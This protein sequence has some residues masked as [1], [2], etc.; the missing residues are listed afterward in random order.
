M[1]PRC[2]EEHLQSRGHTHDAAQQDVSREGDPWAAGAHLSLQQQEQE[3]WRGAEGGAQGT[4]AAKVHL[5]LLLP[6]AVGGGVEQAA[7]RKAW[8]GWRK[9]EGSSQLPGGSQG[10]RRRKQ[11]GWK[12]GEQ[13]GGREEGAAGMGG[14]RTARRRAAQAGCARDRQAA[15]AAPRRTRPPRAPQALTTAPQRSP[16]RRT[17]P[18]G[19]GPEGPP[20]AR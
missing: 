20:P 14:R 10:E 18:G 6:D 17:S 9:E 8:A 15:P 2:S 1:G 11:V 16:W 19:G 3:V 4:A 7:G 13:S 12:G 5:V